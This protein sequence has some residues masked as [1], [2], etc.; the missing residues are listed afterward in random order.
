MKAKIQPR[1]LSSAKTDLSKAVP[2]R[3]PFSIHLDICSKCNLKCNFCFQSDEQALKREN[4]TKGIMGWNLFTKIVDDVSKFNDKI[5]KIKIGLLGEPTLHPQ[6]CEMI[7]Y[8]KS[9]NCTETIEMFTNGLLITPKLSENLI[10]SGLN[11]IN[12]S[13]EGL[14][15]QE[16]K[17][18]TGI[19]I[20]MNKFID[21][22]KYLY[23]VRGKCK[24]YIKTIT[25]DKNK[26]YSMFGDICD[27]IYVENIVPQWAET[28]SIPLGV[29]GMYH[30]DI[31]QYKQV[32]PFIFMYLHYNWDG[33]VSPCTLDW[34][35]KILIGDANIQSALDIWH[36]DK[37]KE[38]QIKHLEN[39][40]NEVNFCNKCLAPMVCCF[41]DLDNNTQELLRR[42]K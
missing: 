17:K 36:S 29:K 18:I 26:F 4:F 24:I 11:R 35:K 19:K 27:E 23:S 14:D 13:V 28:E 33:T 10:E 21:N 41:E 32:C 25:Q 15:S 37:L 34:A 5:R 9:K 30:Q 3:T 7:K 22:I 8:I 12:I 39:K 40:R 38:L 31:K 20:D 16:Y 2:L 42:I 1:I 6:L